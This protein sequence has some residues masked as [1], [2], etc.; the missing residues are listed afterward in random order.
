MPIEIEIGFK[1]PSALAQERLLKDIA[2]ARLRE[3]K[4]IAMTA[5]YYDTP[6]HAL[7]ARSATLRRRIEDGEPFVSLKVAA[8]NGGRILERNMWECSSSE[9]S[10]AMGTLMDMGAPQE[11]LNLASAEG[12][13]AYGRYEY[14][15]SSSLLLIDDE[16]SIEVNFDEGVILSEDKQTE[17]S[18][19]LF[20]LLFG[21]KETLEDYVFALEGKHGLTRVL[22]SKYERVLQMIRSR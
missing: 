7:R 20:K 1:M 6:A 14:T 17:F 4:T 2:A 19:V 16:T 3:P 11:L 21:S 9:V 15:R 8:Q 5:E 13:V 18:E 10:A 12:F 22:S